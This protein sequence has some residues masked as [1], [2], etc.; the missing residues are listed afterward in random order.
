MPRRIAGGRGSSR[1]GRLFVPFQSF[2]RRRRCRDSLRLKALGLSDVSLYLPEVLPRLELR[3]RSLFERSLRLHRL[4]CRAQEVVAG[5]PAM[6][7]V[8]LRFH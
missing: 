3:R 7:Q 2:L 1:R 8:L 4:V 5:V 6:A